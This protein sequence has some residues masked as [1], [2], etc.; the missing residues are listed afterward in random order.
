MYEKK[1]EVKKVATFDS[2]PDDILVNI[3]SLLPLKDR[4]ILTRVASW[5]APLLDQLWSRQSSISF[6]RSDKPVFDTLSSLLV[7]D[8]KEEVFKSVATRILSKC[9]QL[10][11]VYFSRPFDGSILSEFNRHLTEIASQ[12]LNLVSDYVNAIDCNNFKCELTTIQFKRGYRTNMFNLPQLDFL[13]KCPK[14]ENLSIDLPSNV[15]KTLIPTNI[16]DNL[17]HFSLNG[18]DLLPLQ[19][20]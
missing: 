9:P 10:K 7:E 13:E 15:S 11:Q 12:D 5:F 17:Q 4:I 3:F 19:Y 1:N 16:F 14:L 8:L 6:Q 2:L 18:I 20:L